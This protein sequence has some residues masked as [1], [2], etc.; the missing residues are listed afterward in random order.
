MPIQ[1]F[2]HSS[3]AERSLRAGFVVIV[4]LLSAAAVASGD[5]HGAGHGGSHGSFGGGHVGGHSFGGAGHG[6]NHDA[7]HVGQS[8]GG[9]FGGRIHE[10]GHG[11]FDH[12]GHHDDA[13][14][15]FHDFHPHGHGFLGW[16]YSYAYVRSYYRDYCN[17]HSVYYDPAYC[18]QYYPAAYSYDAY[19][20]AYVPTSGGPAPEAVI[21]G[22]GVA[23]VPVLNWTGLL[24]ASARSGQVLA[25]QGWISPALAK[26][27]GEAVLA[28][29]DAADGLKDG[30][31]A[32]PVGCRQKFDPA[33]LACGA[34]RTLLE[35]MTVPVLL[36]H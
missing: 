36:S 17:P 21:L 15:G 25:G 18:T 22:S 11:G 2:V 34:T 5:G 28:A 10:S 20:S 27:Y 1:A 9:H 14:H 29:C 4:A 35:T 33:R 13:H 26:H 30:I 6:F 24:H 16:G 31:V 23:R 8:S 7:G 19:P 3:S 32:D 12:G